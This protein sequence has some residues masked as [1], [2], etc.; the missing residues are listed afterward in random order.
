MQNS[1]SRNERPILHRIV[2]IYFL[3]SF[4]VIVFAVL[5]RQELFSEHVIFAAYFL[6]LAVLYVQ[7]AFT[8]ESTSSEKVERDERASQRL[9][10]HGFFSIFATILMYEAARLT[11]WSG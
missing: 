6:M 2:D 11:Y 4:C 3:V 8:K 5:F 1:E 10:Y 7:N 9:A